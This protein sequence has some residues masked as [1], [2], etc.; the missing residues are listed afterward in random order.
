MEGLVRLHDVVQQV[1]AHE[2]DLLRD[3][4]G[5]WV[6]HARAMGVEVLRSGARVQLHQEQQLDYPF[7]REG[8]HG[9]EVLEQLEDHRGGVLRQ[10]HHRGLQFHHFRARQLLQLHWR[11]VRHCHCNL[12]SF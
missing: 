3:F 9:R 11:R 4:P 10:Q 7:P 5:F 6:G 8:D 2:G 1:E 12:R